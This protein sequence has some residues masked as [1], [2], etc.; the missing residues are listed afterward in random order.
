MNEWDNN[1]NVEIRRGVMIKL[2]INYSFYEV[3]T[4]T[5]LFLPER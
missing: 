1:F 5:I 2:R 4:F 3:K